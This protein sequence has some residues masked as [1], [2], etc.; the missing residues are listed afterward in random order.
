MSV[1]S[2][3]SSIRQAR[4]IAAAE[5]ARRVGVSRQ[6]IY[7]IESGSYVPNTSVALRLARE[8]EVSVE[9]LFALEDSADSPRPRSVKAT[10]LGPAQG[11][12]SR[13]V[14]L[15]RIRDRWIGSPAESIPYYLPEADGIAA[16]PGKRGLATVQVIG[17]DESM[18]KRLVIAGCDP[19]IGLL[20]RMTERASGVDVVAAPASSRQ[21]LDWMKRGMIHIAGSH[22]EDPATGEF[23]LPHLRRLMPDEDLSVVTF[24]R[25]EA[26]FVVARGNPLGIRRA[27]DLAQS[28]VR[29]INREPGSGSRAL[30]DSLLSKA[31]VPGEGIQGYDRLAAGHM[32]AAWAVAA[33]AA[34]CCLA[35]PSAARAFSLD[36][37]PLREERFDFAVPREFLDLPAVRCFFDVLQRASLR[38]KLESLAG[39]DASQTGRLLAPGPAGT[40]R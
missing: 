27:G 7:A 4:G 6:T 2:R 33:G 20:A 24:A 8:L 21:A 22:L 15:T 13:P 5:L 23:N 11:A 38:R 28:R 39:Y 26:G 12:S 16:L 34:D 10:L 25:W 14:R 37:V 31:G 35:T 30:L 36:F 1:E 9:D 3:L 19:A 17:P 40:N 29:F 18:A 32:A